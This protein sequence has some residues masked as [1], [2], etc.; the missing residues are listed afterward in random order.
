MNAQ[1][2]IQVQLLIGALSALLPMAPAELRARLAGVL[3][4]AAAALRAAQAG[5]VELDDLVVKL[6]QARG[7]IE[8]MV[9]VGRA[10]TPARLDEAFVRVTAASAA[11][12]AALARA[13]G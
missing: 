12:R 2:F 1:V 4:L 3:D 11:F 5:A 7:E 13:G 9:E 6:R 8:R 10:V